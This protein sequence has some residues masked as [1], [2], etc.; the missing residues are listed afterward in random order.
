MA[1]TLTECDAGVQVPQCPCRP[2]RDS[3]HGGG[4][5][6]FRMSWCRL[7]SSFVH[8]PK[9]WSLRQALGEP[10]A[11]AYLARIWAWASAMCESGMLPL[12]SAPMQLESAAMWQG[13]P[14]ALFQALLKTGWVDQIQGLAVLHDWSLLNGYQ[15]RESRRLKERKHP[16]SGGARVQSHA[17]RTD[18]RTNIRTE[19][20]PSEEE[21]SSAS[22]PVRGQADELFEHWVT[23]LA[24]PPQCRLT[25]KLRAKVNTA[26]KTYP[27]D[28]L[29]L[30]VV[31]MGNDPWPERKL[32]LGLEYALRD[33]EK[34]VA[35]AGGAPAVGDVTRGVAPP[36]AWG[37]GA[38]AAFVAMGRGKVQ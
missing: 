15:I 38:D 4:R 10:L 36:S 1:P 16:D 19:S 18:G 28:T 34:F 21:A 30:A 24:R 27:L 26:L 22:P 23:T 13:K 14:G 12:E 20:P 3:I 33:V 9:T 7:E 2:R 6:S 35:L 32:H 8:H 31:G 29:K 17:V 5:R 11:D 25:P 37:P